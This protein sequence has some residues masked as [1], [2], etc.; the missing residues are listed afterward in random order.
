M[1]VRAIADSTVVTS[2]MYQ[3]ITLL[4]L[5]PILLVSWLVT[6]CFLY[7]F[8]FLDVSPESIVYELCDIVKGAIVS[9][10]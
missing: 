5:F 4:D 10:K 9:G 8:R 7:L 1:E 3:K 6:I 2:Q